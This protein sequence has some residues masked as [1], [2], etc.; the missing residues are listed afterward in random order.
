MSY[1]IKRTSTAYPLVFLLVSS[2]D[3][4]TGLGG[5]S[6][7]VTLSKNGGAFSACSGAVS[8]LSNGW[9]KVAGNATD[10][11]TAGPL[12]LHASAA[13]ADPC[14][15]VFE[16]VAYLVDELPQAVWSRAA[17]LGL[18]QT[19]GG[20]PGDLEF[21]QDALRYA[22]TRG[23]LDSATAALLAR[24]PAALI[25]GRMDVS[26]GA[27]QADVLTAASLAT[28]AVLEIGGGVVAALRSVGVLELAAG[29][30]GDYRFTADSL[31]NASSSTGAGSSLD[32]AGVRAAIG[33]AAANLDAQLAVLAGY[34]D[35]EVPAIKATT[36]ALFSLLEP[37]AGSPT[38]YRLTAD[39][40]QRS[41]A[42][43]GLAAGNM[44]AQ[45]AQVA[46][47][48]PSSAALA[49]AVLDE[50]LAG[51]MIVGSVGR[52]IFDADKRGARVT[53]RGAVG[54]VPAP[55]TTQFTLSSFDASCSSV[56]Q[57]LGRV[58]VFDKDTTTTALQGQA[59]VITANTSDA[60]PMLTFDALTSAPVAGDTFSIV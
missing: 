1:K 34:V 24:L 51:H 58:I 37:A 35:T 44:D 47:A 2:S 14:D 41:T 56:D 18:V 26:V 57:F 5:L 25:G 50:S 9:Y 46:G 36:D 16:V 15:V 22:A 32:A 40:L 27:M 60:L 53:L 21:T 45:F 7:T 52:A 54:A 19:A 6:P 11:A 10:T 28:D 59:A 55:T 30:P 39:A 12:I 33:M 8:E 38:E 48:L 43:L 29:S 23:Q 31:A 3:H 42:V 4:I 49:D 20:S 13:G 17:E